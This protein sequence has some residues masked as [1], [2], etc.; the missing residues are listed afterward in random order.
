MAT[1]VIF[2]CDMCKEE[3]VIDND[4]FE[5]AQIVIISK[6][7]TEQKIDVCMKCKEDVLKF[8]NK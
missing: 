7:K 2:I 1:K 4:G 3:T 6:N 8:I 5:D